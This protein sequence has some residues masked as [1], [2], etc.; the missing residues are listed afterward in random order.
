MSSPRLY[1]HSLDL[2]R[3]A[4]LIIDADPGFYRN[5]VC[6][7]QR[8]VGTDTRGAWVPLENVW[9]HMD[10]ADHGY[11]APSNFIF[12]TGQCGSTLVSRLLDE[13]P[14]VLGL[15]EPL[16]LRTLAAGLHGHGIRSGANF[17]DIFK[18]SY[19]LLVRRFSPNQKVIIKP[20]S[21]CNNLAAVL[22]AQNPAN[23]G[24]LLF[25]RLE[26]HLAKVL[27]EGGTADI[28]GFLSHRMSSLQKIVPDLDLAQEELSFAEKVAFSWLAEAAQLYT[29]STRGLAPRLL[30][31]DFDAFL[32]QTETHLSNLLRHFSIPAEQET[33]PAMLASPVFGTR[34]K[35]PG[36]ADA[37][38]NRN[39]I[40]NE[41]RTANAEDIKTGM[42]FAE[43][44]MKNHPD[45]G[46]LTEKIPLG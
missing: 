15:R 17:E 26:A 30:L 4:A 2:E 5:A 44:L 10:A 21:M 11:L 34:S 37:A 33:L 3:A 41:S 24:I 46:E 32:A 14:S 19:L 28:D 29:L 20:A 6:L 40:L 9:R 25:V 8:A 13:I 42:Q 43:R 31:M 23:R 1:P 27:A 35:Q 7:D 16:L 22:L 12:H 45:L 18:R 39:A 36:F 38:A